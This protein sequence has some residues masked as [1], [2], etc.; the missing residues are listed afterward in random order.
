MSLSLN[1]QPNP[2]PIVNPDPI[3]SLDPIV[4]PDHT[5]KTK[6]NLEQAKL[7]LITITR[8]ITSVTTATAA[9]AAAHCSIQI[10]D[11]LLTEIATDLHLLFIHVTDLFDEAHQ[12]LTYNN[13]GTFYDTGRRVH[14]LHMLLEYI[15]IVYRVPPHNKDDLALY[16]AGWENKN[17]LAI[18]D[19]SRDWTIPEQPYGLRRREA[20]KIC[21]EFI[22]NRS[23][24]ADI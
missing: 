14:R 18:S 19:Q 8:P 20:E 22:L 15:K 6:A 17:Y 5:P 12:K 10:K 4:S 3:G 21:S 16:L 23:L 11:P 13:E 2:D 24:P 9:A 7:T 1:P